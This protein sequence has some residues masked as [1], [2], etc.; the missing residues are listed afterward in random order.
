MTADSFDIK[1]FDTS[2]QRVA[3]LRGAEGDHGPPSNF[4]APSLAPTSLERYKVLNFE[5]IVYC[6]YLQ[7]RKMYKV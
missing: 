1:W 7:I 4:L 2:P 5:Y 6:K 3:V